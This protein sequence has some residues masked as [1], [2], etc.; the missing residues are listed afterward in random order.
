M[1]G[2]DW[3]PRGGQSSPTTLDQPAGAPWQPQTCRAAHNLMSPVILIL[4]VVDTEADR[5]GDAV[6]RLYWLADCTTILERYSNIR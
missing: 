5:S 4:S 6:E 1:E 3:L 2:S